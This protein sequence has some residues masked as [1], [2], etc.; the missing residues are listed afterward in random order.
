MS[1]A[2]GNTPLTRK[3]KQIRMLTYMANNCNAA[4]HLYDGVVKFL[5]DGYGYSSSGICKLWKTHKT[6][7]MNDVHKKPLVVNRKKGSGRKKKITSTSTVAAVPPRPITL[8]ST[9]DAPIAAGPVTAA[10]PTTAPSSPIPP[11][12]F[13]TAATATT[14]ADP[15]INEQPYKT[16]EEL[17]ADCHHVQQHHQPLHGTL[18]ARSI[19]RDTAVTDDADENDTARVATQCT[20]ATTTNA[21]I[22]VATSLTCDDITDQPI[23]VTEKTPANE[24]RLLR[25]CPV[26]ENYFTDIYEKSLQKKAAEAEAKAVAEAESNKKA[27]DELCRTDDVIEKYSMCCICLDPYVVDADS[28]SER[29]LPIK[30][31]CSHDVCETCLDS[32]FA[33]AQSLSGRKILRYIKCPLCNE[34]KAF[35]IQNKVTDRLLRDLLKASA[36]KT[37]SSEEDS[38]VNESS[39]TD[40]THQLSSE[41]AMLRKKNEEAEKEMTQLMKR[42]EELEKVASE[43]AQLRRRIEELE[44]CSVGN[45][46]I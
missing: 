20:T 4:G 34:K 19:S 13:P 18:G 1:T 31:A 8:I 30:G 24:A 5:M 46:G 11:T 41:V 23:T 3:E 17:K 28:P 9:A 40:D 26:D 16:A 12:T 2:N 42:N 32:Y 38:R 10:P 36:P 33:H 37:G 39:G 29:R 45:G 35:D 27:A 21:F 22:G 6:M 15:P 14:P 44:A 43:N 7:A 25:N